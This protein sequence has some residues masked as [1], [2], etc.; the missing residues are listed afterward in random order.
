MGC[1]KLGNVKYLA[2]SSKIN[3]VYKLFA[4]YICVDMHL[5]LVV[6]FQDCVKLLNI[7]VLRE[8]LK[9]NVLSEAESPW[10]YYS[11]TEMLL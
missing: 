8:D 11:R 4:R 9:S 3:K 5:V 6:L 1:F 10:V 7:N 2:L